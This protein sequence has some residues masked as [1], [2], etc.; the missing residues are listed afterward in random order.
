MYILETLNNK[1]NI[2]ET[3]LINEKLYYLIKFTDGIY[4]KYVLNILE[5]MRFK[6]NAKPT[7]RSGR[8]WVTK[9]EPSWID[10]K[11]VIFK[12]DGLDALLNKFN[13]LKLEE[14]KLKVQIDKTPIRFCKTCKQSKE[15]AITKLCGRECSVSCLSCITI[16]VE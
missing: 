4:R 12:M 2:L 3:K 5:Y 1:V 16:W 6:F 15:V 9:F 8:L 14:K 7:T 13:K 10:A 11:F